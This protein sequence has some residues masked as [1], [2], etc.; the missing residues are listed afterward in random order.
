MDLRTKIATHYIVQSAKMVASRGKDCARLIWN[1][2]EG[3]EVFHLLQDCCFFHRFSYE[4]V[5]SDDI[6]DIELGAI[7]GF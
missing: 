1:I 5:T 6:L 3:S 4:Y 2:V 7:Q